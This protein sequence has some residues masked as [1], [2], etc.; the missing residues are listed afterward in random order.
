VKSYFWAICFAFLILVPRAM[1]QV[2][3]VCETYDTKEIACNDA[4]HTGCPSH[5]A[6]TGVIDGGGADF[7][8]S[9]PVTQSLVCPGGSSCPATSYPLVAVSNPYCEQTYTACGCVG[10]GCVGT[11]PPSC[12]TGAI[13]CGYRYWCISG[14]DGCI[15]EYASPII[16]DTT[17][18]G[19][20]LT[21][22]EDGVAFDIAGNGQRIKMAWTAADSGNAFLALDRNHNGTIDSGKELFGNFTAQPPSLDKNG[23]L[24]LAEFDKLEN[25]GNGDGIID[26]RDA[27]YSKLL[28]WIDV[29]H[30]GISQP[31]ELHTL[32]EL[33]VY[34][35]SLHAT[36]DH[37][38]DSFGNL[39]HYKAALNPNPIDGT[40]KDGRW[41]YDVDFVPDK[42]G[43]P[44]CAPRGKPAKLEVDAIDHN[45]N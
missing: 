31:N 38:E 41:T 43:T 14:V 12:C 20:H 8:C 24:A 44:A 28:L 19:F 42:S 3:T 30:D 21:S 11:P 25:G 22:A 13:T 27:V 37:H 45:L 18:K 40:S 1:A 4:P 5:T 33:G 34:S 32:P 10:A 29:N 7:G 39:F 23:Y 9:H 35:I 36:D 26:S 2:D 15:C 17:G 16:V 6:L